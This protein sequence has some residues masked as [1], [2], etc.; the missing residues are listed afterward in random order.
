MVLRG[1]DM[2]FWER[3]K[4]KY[5]EEVKLFVAIGGGEKK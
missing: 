2:K 4:K 1:R 3:S 5:L